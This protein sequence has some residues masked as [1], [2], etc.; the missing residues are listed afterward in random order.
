MSASILSRR[1]PCFT[2]GCCPCGSVVCSYFTDFSFPIVT[3][4]VAVA[5]IVTTTSTAQQAHGDGNVMKREVWTAKLDC[6]VAVIYTV[7]WTSPKVWQLYCSCYST[8]LDWSHAV[9]WKFILL[10]P[11]SPCKWCTCRCSMLKWVRSKC[12]FET[13]CKS[14][15]EG[16]W[17][18]CYLL[19]RGVL[20]LMNLAFKIISFSHASD[21]GQPSVFLW[22]I[23]VLGNLHCNS[24]M[25]TKCR[26][27]TSFTSSEY[28]AFTQWPVNNFLVG[29][30]CHYVDMSHMRLHM[31]VYERSRHS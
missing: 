8:L 13:T 27:F 15:R 6:T 21:V 18:V 16:T 31:Y 9:F 26:P 2:L 20:E 14:V 1:P 23:E 25:H 4:A 29:F 11:I 24:L 22:I 30:S 12:D 5:A 19:P 10:P 7:V 17:C 3:V 28:W